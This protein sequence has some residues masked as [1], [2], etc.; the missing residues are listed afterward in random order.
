MAEKKVDSK[1]KPIIIALVVMA[2]VALLLGKIFYTMYC[3]SRDT[4]IEHW[5][6]EARKNAQDIKFYMA[7]PM[8]AVSFSAGRVNDFLEKGTPHEEVGEYLV[9]Q[10][11]TYAAEINENSTGVYAY[12]DGEYLDGSG[13]IAPEDYEPTERPWY[14]AAVEADGKIAIA[15]PYYNMQ[16]FTYMMSVSKLLEDKESVVSMDIFLDY[17]LEKAEEA[18]RADSVLECFVVEKDGLIVA[19]SDSGL[20]GSDLREINAELANKVLS[21]AINDE[22]IDD[23]NGKI[24]GDYV[25]VESINDYW[26]LVFIID[27]ADM[28][29][30]LR[31]ILASSTIIILL[32]LGIILATL[33]NVNNRRIQAEHLNR[34][35]GAISDIFMSVLKVNLKKDT[36]EIVCQS[37]T[38]Y[39]LLGTKK[40]DFSRRAIDTAICMSSESSRELL[41]NFINT[42]TLPERMK[43]LDSISMEFVDIHNMWTRIR[44]VIVDRDTEG[45]PYHVLLMTE[46]IDEDKRQQERLKS[47]SEMDQMTGIYN[48]GS[49]EKYIKDLIF[50]GKSGMFCLMD[51]DNFKY[52][53]DNYG[54]KTGDK[55]L[56]EIARCLKSAFRDTDVVFRLGGDEFAVYSVG[57]T[58]QKDGKSPLGRFFNQIEKINIPELQGRPITLSVGATFYTAGML[59]SFDKMYQR[60]DEG[61]YESKKQTGNHVTFK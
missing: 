54:H 57:I 20:V 55:V 53:N 39:T 50:Q 36:V 4:T 16:T 34:E 40:E 59:D 43:D 10:T 37:E 7:K 11:A 42:E 48:R 24:T 1:V 5:M 30:N 6:A 31:V 46:S 8:D 13:W 22:S 51:A 56:I 9:K 3:F 41:V 12:Y 14:K 27:A 28:L 23:L 33:I 19:H 61:T 32:I 52:I 26:K 2:G 17:V 15:E 45:N 44:Y 49:G 60:A 18:S 58:E 38:L 47:L 29:F 25:L 21:S 35:I